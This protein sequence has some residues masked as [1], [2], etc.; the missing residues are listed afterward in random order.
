MSW[1][2]ISARWVWA[3]RRLLAPFAAALLVLVFVALVYHRGYAA[4]KADC[5]E[6]QRQADL[7]AQKR[8]DKVSVTLE[9]ENA[10][11]KLAYRS[12]TAGLEPVLDRTLY[13][14][15]CIDADGLRGVNAALAPRKSDA[16]LP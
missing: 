14:R 16:P 4:G 10:A 7:A 15:E 6:Q 1:A 12:I 8:A 13:S 9:A 5:E 2:L 11:A 3:H